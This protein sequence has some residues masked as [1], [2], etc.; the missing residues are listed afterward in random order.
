[1]TARP[2][3]R[4]A[5][6]VFAG[7][8][9][10]SLSVPA[11]AHAVRG[12]IFYTI[13]GPAPGQPR[14]NPEGV[15]KASFNYNGTTL[16]LGARAAVRNLPNADGLI[17]SPDGDL[18]VGE[19]G[20]GL[21]NKFAPSGAGPLTTVNAGGGQAF[22]LALDPRRDRFWTAGIP[23]S[24]SEVPLSPFANGTGHGVSGDDSSITGIAFD[25]ATPPN[26]YY[27]ASG[28]GG[29]GNVGR[30]NLAT[31]T[32]TRAITAQDGAHSIVYDPFSDTLLLFGDQHITQL[33]LPALTIKSQIDLSASYPNLIL[34][35]GSVDGKGHIFV[36][37]NNGYLV[38]VDYA[39][40]AAL[41]PASGKNQI[42][43]A[44]FT[45]VQFLDADVDDVAPLVDPGGPERTPPTCSLT[46]SGTDGT[47]HAYVEFTVRDT[48]SGIDSITWT[49]SNCTITTTPPSPPVG[50]TLP[51][52]VRATKTNNSLRS[53]VSITVTDVVGNVTECDPV[54]D[55]IVI[56][57]GRV[58]A[59][60]IYAPI[61]EM[62]SYI[63]LRNGTPGVQ[64]ATLR[65]N[66]HRPYQTGLAPGQERV[67]NVATALRDGSNS[68][69]ITVYGKPGALVDVLILDGPPG[70]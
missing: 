56:P 54:L 65:V 12:S 55:R 68:I 53:V 47:G 69:Q 29:H 66:R 21:V 48:G 46:G 37:D 51:V 4:H 67:L 41:A 6:A 1:M 40:T 16:T 24:L 11:H 33:N 17:F 34:D 61:P 28:P 8:V 27:T 31:F 43:Y 13:K 15:K 49:T 10:L 39:N 26:A 18:V 63:S 9:A 25:R 30:I 14:I 60:R 58:S 23:G 3:W 62:E 20:S 57:S 38:F 64:L 7:A 52:V 45:N 44:S 59:T 5:L 2:E 22:H 70:G 32:T 36:G 19:G 42:S 35:Q 50:Y